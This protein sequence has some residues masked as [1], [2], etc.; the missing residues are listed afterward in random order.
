MSGPG[1]AEGFATPV[2]DWGEK[3]AARYDASTSDRASKEVLGPTV[4]FLAQLAGKGRAL[5]LA[6]GTGR[7]AIPLAASGVKVAGIDLSEAMVRRLRQKAGGEAVPVVVGDMTT[8]L[9]PGRFSLVYLVF[10]GLSN[11]TSQAEQVACFHNAARHLDAGG[12]FVIELF[13]PALRRLPPGQSAVPFDVSEDHLGFDTYDTVSQLC[14]SHHYWREEDGTVG[15][16]AGTFRY[17][18]PAECDLMAALAGLSL[19][20]RFS[21]WEKEPFTAESESHVSVYAKP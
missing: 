15:S 7:V 12:R 19:E 1:Q 3:T 13:V 8:T 14:A 21:G 10:N 4:A 17:A 20:S 11:L 9:V 6:I 16:S 18:W 5:E 2:Q